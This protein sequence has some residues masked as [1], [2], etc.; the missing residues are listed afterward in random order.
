M[1]TKHCCDEMSKFIKDK[2]YPILYVRKFREYGLKIF[3]GGTSFIIM[4]FCPWCGKKLP[5]SLRDE[6][7]EKVWALGLE[8]ESKNIPA[9]LKTDK[10][11]REKL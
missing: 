1:K 10:W 9:E 11:W 7:F 3:D 6:W 5:N 2:E 8:P 4:N